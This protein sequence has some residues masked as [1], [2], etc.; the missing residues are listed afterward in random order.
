MLQGLSMYDP[1]MQAV[2][3]QSLRVPPMATADIC[4]GR[5]GGIRRRHRQYRLLMIRHQSIHR[6]EPPTTTSWMLFGRDQR[7]G[8]YYMNMTLTD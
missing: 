2:Q 6:I 5:C 8:Y 1:A 4:T 7:L 3:M